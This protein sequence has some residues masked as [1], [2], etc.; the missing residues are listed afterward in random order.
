MPIINKRK[1]CNIKEKVTLIQEL[2][3]GKNTL[4]DPKI[5]KEDQN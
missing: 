3:F 1:V 4:Y 2:E 5:C